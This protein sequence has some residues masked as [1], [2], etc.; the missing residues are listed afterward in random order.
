M[1]FGRR[2][3]LKALVP[4]TAAP[5]FVINGIAKSE[6]HLIPPGFYL[7]FVD[8]QVVDVQDLMDNHRQIPEGVCIEIIPLKL[9]HEQTIDDAVRIYGLD[10]P[11]D[12]E[13]LSGS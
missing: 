4:M 1:T 7:L 12:R 3:L 9:R 2:E 5:T 8:A 10:H 11:R 6:A 13:T